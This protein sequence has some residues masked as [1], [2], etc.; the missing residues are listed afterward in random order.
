MSCQRK[1]LPHQCDVV[2]L[3]DCSSNDLLVITYND[4]LVGRIFD[5]ANDSTHLHTPA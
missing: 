1:G 4:E 3:V 2:W 5:V